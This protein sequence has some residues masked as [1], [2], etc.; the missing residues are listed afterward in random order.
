MNILRLVDELRHRRA[1]AIHGGRG[2][3]FESCIS[4]QGNVTFKC[5]CCNW[6]FRNNH[7]LN[8]LLE[9]RINRA[10][11]LYVNIDPQNPMQLITPV[12]TFVQRDAP[13]VNR[14]RPVNANQILVAEFDNAVQFQQAVAEQPRSPMANA[15]EF[16]DQPVLNDLLQVVQEDLNNQPMPNFQFGFVNN[17]FGGRE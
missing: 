16:L 3:D 13:A 4:F 8:H 11:G 1:Y 5:P 10:A 17:N 14:N 6:V 7:L 15:A 12:Q 2:D 9:S